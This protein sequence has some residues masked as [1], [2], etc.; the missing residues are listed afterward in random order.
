MLQKVVNI[1][2]TLKAFC[3]G[4]TLRHANDKEADNFDNEN[5]SNN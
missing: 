4:D 5:K 3:I 1:R 2:D